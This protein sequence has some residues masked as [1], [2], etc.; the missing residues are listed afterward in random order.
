MPLSKISNAHTGL[1]VAAFALLFGGHGIL[2]FLTGD[3]FLALLGLVIY[4][5]M[6]L[7]F[8]ITYAVLLWRAR[9]RVS[10]RRLPVTLLGFLLL[11]IVSIAWSPDRVTS[12]L[13]AAVLVLT[14]IIGLGIALLLPWRDLIRALGTTLRWLL[15]LSL[16]FEIYVFGFGNGNGF[17]N[18]FYNGFD[19]GVIHGIVGA[20]NE[21]GFLALI[22][23]IVFSLQLVDGTVWRIWGI[24]WLAVALG[25]L[26]LTHSPTVLLPAAAV[27]LVLGFALWARAT[28]PLARRGV[29]AVAA[30]VLLGIGT[31]GVFGVLTGG[32][33]IWNIP[34]TWR[35][36]WG[37][38][39]II[40]LVVCGFFVLSTTWRAWFVAIDRPRWDLN[41]QRPFTANSLLPLLILVA[42]LTQSVLSRPQ[43]DQSG[44]ALLV[45]CAV[46]MKSPGRVHGARP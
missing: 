18:G 35:D 17:D 21:L 24:A 39:G 46:M 5:V 36:I 12:I 15:A 38:L 40:G 16:A 19:N 32:L 31:W 33:T 4:F 22:A 2:V 1:A 26:A 23:L 27:L 7:A 6:A 29:Y 37:R 11:V 20:G 13:T 42:L 45:I 14:T 25:T 8:A 30:L 28:S 9:R 44:W 41:D 34:N 3:Y 10:L 43:L